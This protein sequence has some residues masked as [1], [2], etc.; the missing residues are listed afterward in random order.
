[1]VRIDRR[2]KKG[3]VYL[4]LEE[5]GWI[6]GKSKRLWQRYLGPEHKFKELSK[7]ALNLDI[8]TGTMEFG[9]IASLL[10]IAKKLDL[11]NIIN[12]FTNKRKQGLSVGEHVLFAA[13]NRCVEPVSKSHLKEWFE[14]TVIKKIYPEVG[15]ALNSR[16]YWAHY[17]YLEKKI[18]ESIG[19][20]INH[21][22]IGKFNVDFSNLLYDPTNFFT[23]INPKMPNQT[24][25]RHGHCK[26]GRFTLNIVNFSLFCALDGGIPLLHLV[27]PGNIPDS[28]SFKNALERLNQRLKQIGVLAPTT[29]LT[30]D[31]GN[32]SKDAF[33]FID[34]EKFEYIA[35]IRPSTR[36]ILLLIPPEEFEMNLLPN[37]KEVGVKEFN[38]EKYDAFIKQLE[39][40]GVQIKKKKFMTYGKSRRIIALYNPNQARWQKENFDKKLKDKLDKIRVFFKDRLNNKDW[41]NPDKVL[42]K[43]Q[44]ILE[45]KKFQKV[46]DINLSGK[47]GDLTLS[48]SQNQTAFEMKCLSFGKSFLMTSREDL[49]AWE[50]AWAYRQQYI[51]ENAF[52][53]LKNPKGLSIRPMHVWTDPSIEGHSF[54]CF[55]GLLLLSLLIRELVMKDI[56]ISM[57]KAIQ[58]LTSIKI[59]KIQIPG[60][61]KPIYK[62][63]KMN[64]EEK[65]L[66]N[67]LKLNRFI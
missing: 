16:S 51:V 33:A 29:T 61:Q 25:P 35:S 32:L 13:I 47:E 50:V 17:R 56:P 5:R 20:E 44:K 41:S 38:E 2:K 52:K 36:K 14:S 40:N 11:V 43:C 54:V 64:E 7:I 66:Y 67:T 6:D 15:S 22:L 23:Y 3:H 21:A 42:E 65:R 63:N 27:Y 48:V 26:E 60:R 28:K 8:E 30:F 37:G 57:T 19:D 46:V 4:Y 62:L 45:A 24:L 31:K 18:V 58:R 1:M 10:F 55:I 59:T 39:L 34:L 12:K 9:L 49:A 53:V